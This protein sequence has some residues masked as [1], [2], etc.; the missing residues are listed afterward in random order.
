MSGL[1]DLLNQRRS[2]ETGL[3]DAYREADKLIVTVSSAVL[4]LSVAF[5]G[6]VKE[7]VNTVAITCSWSLFLASIAMVLVSLVLEQR[8]RLARI[9]KI[10]KAIS[11]NRLDHQDLRLR[12]GKWAGALNIVGV[13][14]F[15]L[16]FAQLASFL[17]ANLI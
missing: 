9:A 2:L 4:A 11:A 8:E 12:W 10:D 5:V 3:L 13:V 17:S 15:I 6:Q 1:S 14:S 7:P 16:A